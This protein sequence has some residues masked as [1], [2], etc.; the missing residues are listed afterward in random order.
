MLNFIFLSWFFSFGLGQFGNLFRSSYGGIYACDFLA[1]IW[2]LYATLYLLIGKKTRIF[3]PKVYFLFLAFLFW[4]IVL[5]VISSQKFSAE[6]MILSF[7]YLFRLIFY[8]LGILLFYNL[9]YQNILREPNVEKLILLEALFLAI[10]GFIQ[11]IVFPDFS[12]IDPGLG[13]D[14]HKNRLLGTFFDPNFMGATLVGLV[15][16]L[17]GFEANNPQKKSAPN[18]WLFLIFLAIFLTFSRSAWL[19]LAVSIFLWG[20]VKYRGLLVVS[21]LIALLAYL[22]IP[23]VQT[24]ISSVTDPADSAHFRLISWKNTLKVAKDNLWLGFGYNTFR[25]TQKDYGFLGS[26]LGGHSGG[27]SDSS[28]LLILATTGLPGFF[29]F[30]PFLVFPW[31]SS[32]MRILKK[33]DATSWD[34]TFFSLLPAL[35]VNSFFINSLF[36]PPILFLWNLALGGTTLFCIEPLNSSRKYFPPNP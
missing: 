16:I 6:E 26:G 21:I 1:I 29:L 35:L 5:Y 23:R 19:M 11:L 33:Q 3:I 13:W 25:F 15:N 14:P 34:F 8:T 31:I 27:G 32:G 20:I 22:A 18:L 30:L 2:V 24:R 9:R 17:L 4:N 7:F 28:L 12:K 36:Y 10:S